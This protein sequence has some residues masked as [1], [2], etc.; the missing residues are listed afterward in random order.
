MK[1]K[2]LGNIIKTKIFNETHE[3]STINNVKY[4]IINTHTKFIVMI[5][6]YIKITLLIST[7]SNKSVF[8]II[9]KSE[10]L[11]ISFLIVIF[12]F[13]FNIYK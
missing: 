3:K 5:D 10:T 8:G 2:L 12:S 6:N 9:L 4:N 13:M 11:F 7:L 1:T